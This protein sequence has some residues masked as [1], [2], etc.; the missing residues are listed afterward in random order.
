MV[1][2]LGFPA[3]FVCAGHGQNGFLTAALLGWGLIL[4]DRRPILAGVCFGLLAYKPQ[5]AVILPLALAAGLAGR[6]FASAAV[7]VL[8]T[9]AAAYGVLGAAPFHGFL[10]ILEP[11]RRLILEE[12]EPGLEK[13]QSVFGA[14]RLVGGSLALA[15]TAQAA[16]MVAAAIAVAWI[17][18]KSRDGAERAAALAFAV[19]LTTPI[20]STTT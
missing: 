16:A 18:W 2:A 7:T 19:P 5:L 17:W 11:T 20:S 6:A 14:V 13:I 3:V 1:L 15:G 12:G 4:L 10:E 8:V 9:Q